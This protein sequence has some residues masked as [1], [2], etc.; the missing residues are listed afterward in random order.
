MTQTWVFF[1][2]PQMI[3]VRTENHC[4]DG[5]SANFFCLLNGNNLHSISWG[6]CENQMRLWMQRVI[7]T[8]G[9]ESKDSGLDSR[10]GAHLQMMLSSP[11]NWNNTSACGLHSSTVPLT[12]PLQAQM[13]STYN[14]STTFWQ[15]PLTYPEAGQKRSPDLLISPKKIR[16]YL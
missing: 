2:A 13:L 3:A 1:K 14:S 10:G 4:T 16:H 15:L 6:H 11:L 7:S 8:V 9:P 5:T 12:R